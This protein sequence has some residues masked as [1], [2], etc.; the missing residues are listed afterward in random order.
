MKNR[1]LIILLTFICIG[2]ACKDSNSTEEPIQN[3]HETQ[4]K[5][6][7]VLPNATEVEATKMVY[8]WV[9]LLRVR[10]FPNSKSDILMKIP[11]GDSLIFL[12]EETLDKMKVT[13]RGKVF[14]E[15]WLKVKTRNETI[16]WVYGGGVTNIAP[17]RDHSPLPF[18]DC[19]I[20]KNKRWRPD[21]KCIDNT[22]L[23]ELRNDKRFVNKRNTTLIFS[24]LNGE[25][26]SLKNNRSD[27]AEKYVTYEYRYYIKKMGFFVAKKSLYE[28]TE[29]LLINDKTGEEIIL[30]GF[31]KSS[32]NGKHLVVTSADLA[33][34]FDYNGVQIW[35]L[36][37]N[38]LELVW[39][40]E[41]EN[42]EPFLPKWYNNKTIQITLQK[43]AQE[44]TQ[45][46][47]TIAYIRL[48][49]QREWEMRNEE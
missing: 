2:M 36:G 6:A 10:E 28:G 48:G 40:K 3:E 41:M 34:G 22:G 27:D 16:G 46:E 8:A 20:L 15:P 13:L 17:P 9:D 23:K 11:E 21:Y 44:Q 32:P 25:S 19:Y 47:P 49:D 39:E 18:D 1:H 4:V 35:H 31:P 12:G 24:L 33:A 37:D 42:L 29:Y 14:N 5:Q 30:E 45:A 43:P 26:K 38:G 7:E